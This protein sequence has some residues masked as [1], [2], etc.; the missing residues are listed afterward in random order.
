MTEYK[1]KRLRYLNEISGKY[2]S[3]KFLFW[4]KVKYKRFDLHHLLHKRIDYLIMP[5]D[6]WFHLGTVEKQRAKYFC[7]YLEVSVILLKE[8]LMEVY[9]AD[10]KINNF[11]PKELIKLF[12]FVKTKEGGK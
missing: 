4:A 5:L 10:Y 2:K 1:M 11:G 6:H 3:K 7:A 12:D 8:Y 9:G